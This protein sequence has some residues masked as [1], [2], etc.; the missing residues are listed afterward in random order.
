MPAAEFETFAEDLLE[1]EERPSDEEFQPE[2]GARWGQWVDR[3][4][5]GRAAGFMG[6]GV[7]GGRAGWP[8]D[9]SAAALTAPV[10]SFLHPLVL[11]CRSE[12]FDD[13]IA[14]DEDEEAAF[15]TRTRSTRRV[16]AT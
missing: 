9:V 1:E 2:E 16:G 8:A 12:D 5:L 6:T 10:Y 7:C 13:F 15:I 11:F 14:G 4:R 3:G